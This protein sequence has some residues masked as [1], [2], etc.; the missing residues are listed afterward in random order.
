MFL[1]AALLTVR[2]IEHFYLK[3]TGAL[4]TWLKNKVDLLRIAPFLRKVDNVLENILEKLEHLSTD[5]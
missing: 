4:P 1:F 5:R 3:I 2:K